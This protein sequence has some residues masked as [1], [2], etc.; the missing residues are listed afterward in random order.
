[1]E[2]LK[3]LL[4]IFRYYLI[5]ASVLLGIL[6]FVHEFGHFIV[7]KI[8]GVRVLKFSL[9]F[10]PK[11]IG[12]KIG[13]TEYVLSAL[14][15]G[16]YVKPL[17]ESPD[18]PVAEQDKPFS[19][20]H[21]SILKRFAIVVA[22]SLFNIM[23]ATL[24]FSIIYM[25]GIPMLIPKVGNVLDDTPAQQAGLQEGDLIVSI[26][27]QKIELW[28]ELSQLIETSEGRQLQL[29]VKR[30]GQ[31][32][33]MKLVPQRTT[34]PDV[35][36]RD[37]QTYK[38]G[39]VN[40]TSKDAFINKKY[41]P[42]IALWKSLKDTWKW[43]KLTF[44]GI[45]MLIRSPIERRKDIGGPIL[46]GKLAG[47]FA[48]VGFLSFVLLMAMISVNL[49]VLNLLPI[50]IL[51]GGHIFFLLLEAIKGKPI[52]LKKMEIAQQIGL[53]ILLTLMIF[54]FYNDIDRFGD[55]TEYLTKIFMA[56]KNLL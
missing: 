19:M 53:A 52:S 48:A 42:T 33:S 41:N 30:N 12:K 11:I 17:G 4:E 56:V 6:I 27:G 36:G 47:D 43:S 15:L 34:A 22:G 7:A 28:E 40:A 10:G 45:G 32:A 51:D 26:N 3:D 2:N 44:V 38:I 14:P 21:Q 37:R 18:D 16:G 35:F 24:L 49:G 29:G 1:M 25:A 9:G 39:I 31:I 55:L 46:I 13:E 23:F 54:V 8:V 5:P 50:P 20:S